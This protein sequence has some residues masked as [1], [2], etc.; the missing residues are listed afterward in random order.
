MKFELKLAAKLTRG[1]GI[2]TPELQQ[3]EFHFFPHPLSSL[4][5]CGGAETVLGR[6]SSQT[7][8]TVGCLRERKKLPFCV[9]MV[10]HCSMPRMVETAAIGLDTSGDGIGGNDKQESRVLF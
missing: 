9:G 7:C 6:Y 10:E 3:N 4:S 2:E 5:A 1:E 8:Y